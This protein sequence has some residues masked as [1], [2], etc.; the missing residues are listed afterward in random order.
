MN[1][2]YLLYSLATLDVFKDKEM[3]EWIKEHKAFENIKEVD[4]V[5]KH[6]GLKN[7]REKVDSNIENLDALESARSLVSKIKSIVSEKCKDLDRYQE[8]LYV[9]KQD[10]EPWDRVFSPEQET[11][12]NLLLKFNVILSNP[13]NQ[14]VKNEDGTVSLILGDTIYDNINQKLVFHKDQSLIKVYN[15]IS[16]MLYKS[17]GMFNLPQI[18]KLEAFKNF[19]SINVPIS[20]MEVV[21]SAD[22]EGAWD[23]CTMSERG[24]SS[25]QKWEDEEYNKS[26]IGSILSKYVGIIYLTSGKDFKG[27]GPKMV[28][29]S[30]VRFITGLKNKKP[31]IVINRMYPEE[32]NDILEIFREKLSKHTSLPVYYIDEINI[33]NYRIPPEKLDIEPEELPYQDNPV[34][35]RGYEEK[36]IED[37]SHLTKNERFNEVSRRIYYLMK[38]DNYIFYRRFIEPHVINSIKYDINYN[39][40]KDYNALMKMV[41]FKIIS[42]MNKSKDLIFGKIKLNQKD[43]SDKEINEY[44]EEVLNTLK[45][46]FKKQIEKN[47]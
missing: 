10:L 35:T 14:I 18:E 11:V 8:T 38:T 27:K 40:I 44:F 22:K 7:F 16:E 26:L 33:D 4:K 47:I 24:I 39:H 1:Y 13:L 15:K 41:L 45:H 31:I 21:F 29:R 28:Y 30:I 37:F 6:F 5:F 25:C 20:K 43:L 2:V 23:L 34:Q 3:P 46:E 9:E 12:Y 19:S 36:R 17:F 42:Y 32:N